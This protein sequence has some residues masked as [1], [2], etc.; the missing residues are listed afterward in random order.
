MDSVEDGELFDSKILRFLYRQFVILPEI[1][2]VR[3]YGGS[4]RLKLLDIA[5]GTGWTTSVWQKEN[6]DV[7]GLESSIVRSSICR[8]RYN[9]EIFTGFIE[10]FTPE[11]KFDV[12]TMR[13][14]LE[15]IENPVAVLEK[16]KSFLKE[17]GILLITLPN[18]NSIGRYVFQENWEWVLPWHLH[19]YYPKTLDALIE[20]MG[21]VKLKIYQM[22]SPLW[23][24]NCFKNVFSKN[25]FISGILAKIP[26][27]VLMGLL[28]PLVFIG[29]L[30]NLNDNLTILARCRL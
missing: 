28:S 17:N 27:I 20:R 15:H 3:K 2:C 10:E 13:H 23:Y 14:I 16:V 12:V 21:L 29:C 11:E 19:F 25:A 4:G 18:I 26:H 30:L 24:P 1:H 22:P 6:F 5:C 7:I 9:L 8:Q